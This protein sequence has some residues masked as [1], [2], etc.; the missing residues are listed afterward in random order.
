ML[1]LSCPQEPDAETKLADVLEQARLSP[2]SMQSV[3]GELTAL[4]PMEPG[5]ERLHRLRSRPRRRFARRRARARKFERSWPH[6]AARP[7]LCRSCSARS[8]RAARRSH[9]LQK[10]RRLRPPARQRQPI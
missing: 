9:L 6:S 5:S 10:M 2:F 8:K 7:L 3:C 4:V 1:R